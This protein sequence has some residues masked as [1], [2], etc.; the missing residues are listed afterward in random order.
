MK[1]GGGGGIIVLLVVL[2][3]VF[4][5][6][7]G[8][9]G[10]LGSLA[11]QTVG[12]GAPPGDLAQECQTGADA[13]E[14]RTVGSSPP[15][16]ACRRTGRRRFVA[17]SRRRR[18]CSTARSRPDA[19]AHPRRSDRSTARTTAT[20]TSTSASSISSSPSSARAAGRSQRRTSSPTSTAITSRTYGVLRS[21]D[22]DTGPQ[23]GQVRVELQADCYAGL[24]VGNALETG[25][26][27]D[28]RGR[29]S[30]MRSTPRPQSETTA[31]RNARKAVSCPSPGRTAPPS[32]AR[33]GSSVGSR[34]RVRRAAT[35]SRAGSRR[36]AKQALC[37]RGSAGS[38]RGCVLGRAHIH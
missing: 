32:S 37:R 17:T 16:T 29:T 28:L 30:P 38:P 35:P 3:F 8:G 10:D 34:A 4:L 15:S 21:A 20:S 33:A 26:V 18:A 5:G 2:A 36:F 19:A 31:S 14:R 1:L 13:N 23:G 22:R 9:L 12:P 11:G 27:E 24:W 6:G 25:F 7:G